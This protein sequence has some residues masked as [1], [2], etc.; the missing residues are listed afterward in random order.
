[1]VDLTC[2]LKH[3]TDKDAVNAVLKAAAE[4][5]LKG[6][7]GYTDLPLV[8]TDFT[9]SHYGG[10]IDGLSTTVLDKTLLKLIIWYDNESGF[11]HQLLRLVKQVAKAL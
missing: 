11:S 9:G 1:M 3:P 2:E 6:N 8:S 7:M 10:V 4:G 5:P